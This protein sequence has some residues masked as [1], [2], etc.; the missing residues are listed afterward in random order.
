MG[1]VVKLS[2]SLAV[3]AVTRGEAR[4]GPQSLMSKCGHVLEAVAD[5]PRNVSSAPDTAANAK[6]FQQ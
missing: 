4:V 3:A 6:K 1:L 5:R 2:A